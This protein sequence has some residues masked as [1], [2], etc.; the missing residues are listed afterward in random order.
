MN[1]DYK[2]QNRKGQI[3]IMQLLKH[4][5]Q[6]VRPYRWLVIVTLVLTLISSLLTSGT[7]TELY[8]HGGRYKEI[9]DASARSMNADKIADVMDN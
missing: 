8:R 2:Q 7:P 3:G 9:F 1:P 5:F 4:I 6:Y